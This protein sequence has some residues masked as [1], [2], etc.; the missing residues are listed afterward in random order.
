MMKPGEMLVL[1]DGLYLVGIFSRSAGK[2]ILLENADV[3][4][5]VI[6]EGQIHWNIGIG[7]NG[8][9]SCFPSL[10]WLPG[11]FRAYYKVKI[12]TF[13]HLV[14]YAHQHL[15]WM[16]AVDWESPHRSKQ[17]IDRKE[18]GL[19]LDHRSQMAA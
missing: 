2:F 14:H 8:V 18:E 11:T 7:C 10:N 13:L 1:I 4:C 12:A 6:E 19:F 16:R 3:F 5:L 17:E 15:L 9:V